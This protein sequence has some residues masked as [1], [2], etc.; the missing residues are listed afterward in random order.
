MVRYESVG[1]LIKVQ[2]SVRDTSGG[3]RG[4]HVDTAEGVVDCPDTGAVL[5]CELDGSDLTLVHTGLRNPQELAFDDRGHLFTGDNNAD[6]GDAARLVAIVEGGDSGWRQPYQWLDGR[7][8]WGDEQLWQPHFAG[9]SAAILPPVAHIASGPSGLCH[10]P[11][12]GLLPELDDHFILCDFTGDAA[13]S[14]LLAFSVARRGASWT[15]APPTPLLSG[16]LAT[17]C[18]FGPDGAL[19]VSDW[20]EGWNGTG[21]G[22]I[23][24]VF[25]PGRRGSEAV[26]ETRRRLT[27]GL[28][29]CPI[30]EL[31]ELLGHADQR[32]RLDAELELA[33]RGAVGRFALLQRAQKAGDVLPRLHAFW[34]L[35]I[36]ARSQPGAAADLPGLADDADPDVRAATL[37]LLGEC[38]PPGA[39][40]AVVAHLLDEDPAVAAAAALAAGR[41]RA[42]QAVEPLLALLV[43]AGDD[44]PYLRHAAV[45]GLVGCD[46]TSHLRALAADGSPDVRLGAVLALR[47]RA[48]PG[49]AAFLRDA[50]PRVVLDAARAIHDL[51]VPDALPALADLVTAASF[52]SAPLADGRTDDAPLVRRVL[53]ANLRLGGEA[54]A[55]A[56]ADFALRGDVDERHRLTALRMLEGFR[57]PLPRD[58]VTGFHRP[59]P[60]RETPWLAGVAL[61]L[62][63]GGILAAPPE[64]VLSFVRLVA[65]SRCAALAEPLRQWLLAPRESSDLRVA[66]L[67]ALETLA[68]PDLQGLV[69]GALS[70]AD[71]P[72]RAA[73]LSA[74]ERL[75]PADALPRLPALLETGDWPE[76]RVA[77]GILG[78]AQDPRADELLRAQL[79]LLLAGLVPAELALDL[80]LA[81]AERD[82]AGVRERLQ[83]HRAGQP[84][85]P[86]LAGRLE[87]LLGGD[88]EAGRAVFERPS[89]SCTRC[90]ATEEGGSAR[91]GPGLAGTG[92]RLARLQILQAIV[93]PNRRTAPGYASLLL[94]QTDGDV[95]SG[96]L[97]D[98]AGGELRVQESSGQ[99]R[100]IPAASVAERRQGLSPMPEGLGASLPPRDLR[101]LIEYVASL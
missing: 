1:E 78:R 22:R 23:W 72:L 6:G 9:Q 86:E 43:R 89:L 13:S 84:G 97:L 81:A 74:L 21:K 98:E 11:S 34:G 39:A 15:M 70:D 35:G 46:D 60:A 55:V 7:G 3:D 26:A 75:S 5:R 62:H 69:A 82:D 29:G 95:V 37:A 36:A 20:V 88:R 33:R 92:R 14:S 64:H 101:D 32:V 4:L 2:L 57:E 65:A 51:P 38:E 77:Y 59:L 48:D 61:R 79:D 85:D 45:M 8:P 17:D 28:D 99:V 44:D 25:D 10:V 12:A 27:E 67:E 83:R 50:D 54:R 41:L 52:V 56:L 90:H 71:G 76:Q 93:T 80:V 47:R 18:D 68:V 40:R 91:V 30:G 24:R 53:N 100:L 94:V 96:R 19:Y 42:P 31:S 49:L 63:A 73:A 66:S 16:A 87:T 58:L